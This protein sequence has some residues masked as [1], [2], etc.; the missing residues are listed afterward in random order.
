MK[1]YSTR[2]VLLFVLAVSA[3]AI[4]SCERV[5]DK[6]LDDTFTIVGEIQPVCFFVDK[7]LGTQACVSLFPPNTSPE[8]YELKPSDL[9]LLNSDV[10]LFFYISSL[11]NVATVEKLQQ[12]FPSIEF[13]DL[14]D[15]Y[16]SIDIDT[17]NCLTLEARMQESIQDLHAHDAHDAHDD[18]DDHD[19]GSSGSE[20]A[21]VDTAELGLDPN[22]HSHSEDPHIWLSLSR[23]SQIV[24]TIS[25]ALRRT[26]PFLVTT[27][28]ANEQRFNAEIDLKYTESLRKL[29]DAE[30][31][32]FAT[33]H[34]SLNYYADDYGLCYLALE[35]MG[36]SPL[37][38]TLENTIAEANRLSIGTV[39]KQEGFPDN[40]LTFIAKGAE[41]EIKSFD[42]M[43]YNV[44]ETIDNITEMLAD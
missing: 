11:G 25:E 10:D 21:V 41:A 4:T 13:V 26:Y 27:I 1:K 24:S 7:V 20:I 29:I 42:P 34:P 5:S 37:P 8:V 12:T 19:Y 36:K 3:L 43:R 23:G 18:H 22:L 9:S 17:N 32:A 28:D 30:V 38:Q 2:Y 44:F 15:I 6:Q 39:L 35:Y 31:S 40:G 14:L 33:Y 16:P